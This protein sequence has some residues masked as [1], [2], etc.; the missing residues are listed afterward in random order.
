[1]LRQMQQNHNRETQETLTETNNSDKPFRL[2]GNSKTHTKSAKV[3]KPIPH[4]G[5]TGHKTT[6]KELHQ[7]LNGYI[8]YILH[9][10]PDTIRQAKNTRRTT[11]ANYPNNRPS[12]KDHQRVIKQI[13][14]NLHDHARALILEKYPTEYERIKKRMGAM[15]T[16]LAKLVSLI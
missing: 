2:N 3:A 7:K 11:R 15:S 9:R 6:E 16:L 12:D 4:K 13:L 14:H 10:Q 1:M 5:E 8:R